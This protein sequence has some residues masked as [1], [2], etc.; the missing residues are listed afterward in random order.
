MSTLIQHVV[1]ATS[2][3]AL[4]AVLAIGIALIF[5][6]MNLMNL[7]YGE[8]IMIGAYTLYALTSLPWPLQLLGCL[9]VTVVAA[10]AMERLAFRPFRGA[11]GPVLLVTSF[12]LSFALQSLATVI[13][14][15]RAKGVA[16]PGFLDKSISIG[17]VSFSSLNLVSVIAAIVLVT[18]LAAGLRRS[19]VGV[20]MRAAAESFATARLLG[21]KANTVIA[22][23]FG[24]SGLFAG[25]AAILV[26]AQNG[27]VTPTIGAAPVL[28]AFV[29]T[30]IGGLGSLSGAAWGGFGLGAVTV[31]LQV[32]LP[33]ALAPYRDAFLYAGVIVVLLVRPQG[34]IVV[35]ARLERV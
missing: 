25:V 12:A 26:V 2:L 30:I 5:G 21:V 31:A 3:G 24:I 23:A 4:Y 34:L 17:S 9:I 1:D 16:L 8:L 13:F 22:A 7:A 11:S 27:T 15:S 35:R 10:L 6:I 32:L 28:V 29:A 19:M 33:D 20:Q 18:G 14:T